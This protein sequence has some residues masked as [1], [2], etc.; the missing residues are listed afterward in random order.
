M[1]KN[2]SGGGG[3]GRTHKHTIKFSVG[4]GEYQRAKEGQ[5]EGWY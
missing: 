4:C 2:K 1:T 5:E 3:G